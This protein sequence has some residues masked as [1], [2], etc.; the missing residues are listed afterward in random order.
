MLL[1]MNTFDCLI[2]VPRQVSIDENRFFALADINGF[3]VEN[4]FANYAESIR[5]LFNTF[6]LAAE[7]KS[8]PRTAQFIVEYAPLPPEAFKITVSPGAIVIQSADSSGCMYALNAFMQMLFAATIRGPKGARLTCGCVED[9]PRFAFRS[10]H[11]DSARH[12][13]QV[14]VIKRMLKLMA[15]FRLNYFHWHLIDSQGWRLQLKTSA[16]LEN[17]YTSTPGFYTVEDIRDVVN[18]ARELN[19]SVIPEMDFPG[20]SYGTLR[21]FPQYACVNAQAPGEFCL[22]NQA[23]K[24]FIK[25]VLLEVMELFPESKYIHIGGDEA[26]TANWDKCPVCRQAMQENNCSNMRELENIFMR[27]IAQFVLANDRTPILWGTCSGQ[28]YQPESIIQSWLD[29]R[30]PLRVAPNGN[31]VIYSVHTS[32]YFDYPANLSEPW[33]TWMFELSERG[34]YM[35]DPHIIWADKVKDVIMGTE[36]CLWTETIPQW[37]VIPKLLPRLY[38]YSECAWSAPERKTYTDFCRRKELLEAAGFMD[39]LIYSGN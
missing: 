1:K 23:G 2:P 34:V 35:T 27:D 19:I 12:F 14:A 22:G 5:Q 6:S 36:A 32:L 24:N 31:K 4:T 29:I 16:G 15:Q 30:E 7:Q 10:F 33:E 20:H 3:F 11:L 13:Q 17:Q 21:Y 28:T 38:A 25:N 8:S 39:F 37:R 9:A 18:T 26:E